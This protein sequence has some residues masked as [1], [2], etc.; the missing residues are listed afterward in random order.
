MMVKVRVR[1]WRMHDVTED[2]LKPGTNVCSGQRF[3]DLAFCHLRYT[4]TSVLIKSEFF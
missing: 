3:R 2:P 4:S 1:G